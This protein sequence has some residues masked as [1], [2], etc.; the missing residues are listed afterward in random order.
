MTSRTLL[1]FSVAASLI[2]LSGTSLATQDHLQPRQGDDLS[3]LH[4][5]DLRAG[6]WIFHNHVL[7]ERLANNHDWFDY[8]GV[9]HLWI[10]MGGYGNMDDNELRRPDGTYYGLTVRTYDPKTGTW[11]IWWYDGRDPAA[12]LDP[13]VKG[14][15]KDG[16]GTFYSGDTL[17]GKP[18]K[19][20]FTWSS[21]TA[22]AAHWEQAFSGDGGKS[23]ETNWTADFSKIDCKA[24]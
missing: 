5:F 21:I 16:V 23:W 4:A 8:D 14:R 22:T 18:I 24:D 2:G 6:C 12:T 10:T 1:K 9:Q 11:S 17:R 19:V 15:F 13:P 20:R 7:K 3:G